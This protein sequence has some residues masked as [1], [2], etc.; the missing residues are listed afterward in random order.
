MAI[1]TAG[2]GVVSI[3]QSNNKSPTL[4]YCEG[5]ED[6]AAP[7]ARLDF[8][9][10]GVN[11]DDVDALVKALMKDP[12]I[13]M[14]M[15]PD[16]LE[17]QLYKSIIILTLNAILNLLGYLQ[18]AR[19]LSHELSMSIER[20]PARGSDFAK[21][22]A[23]GGLPG[24][25]DEVLGQVAKRLL[26][27]PAVNSALLPDKLEEQIYTSCLQVMF[28][29][30]QIILST[31]KIHICGHDLTLKLASK[32]GLESAI[33]SAASRDVTNHRV[34]PIDLDLLTTFARRSGVDDETNTDS[35]W[36]RMFTRSDFVRQLHISLYGLILGILDD[37]FQ[38]Q[39]KVQI[40]SD[41]ISFDLVPTD[42]QQ[43]GQKE[44]TDEDES[45]SSN[46]PYVPPG[47]RVPVESFAAASFAAGVGL[48]V[49]L[50]A[51]LSHVQR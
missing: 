21:T 17:A 32:E 10:V 23:E 5:S 35:G 13:N 2:S 20:D 28:R 42:H 27:N 22:F 49:T 46:F 51:V 1:V 29:V 15:L 18:G 25:N 36:N 16:A 8:A 30:T 43:Y 44:D 37:L 14:T 6:E 4:T 39:L 41:T 33:L 3:D 34:T 26:A 19:L 38:G 48:G 50:M 31:F 47:E 12:S 9:S 24:V 40:L 45:A 7:R 11:S